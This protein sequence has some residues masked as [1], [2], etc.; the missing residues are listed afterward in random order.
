[1]NAALR[2]LLRHLAVEHGR[3]V[4]LYRRIVRP[5][6]DE[7]AAYL[8]RHGGLRAMGE[9]CSIQM[10]TTISD[11][12]YVRLGDNVRLSGCTLFGHDGSVNM[13]AAA[14]GVVL[15]RVGP[16]DIRDHV[17][18]G[19]GAVVLPG[20]TIGPYALVAAGAVVNRDVPP[21]S[22]VGGVPARP[23]G[24]LD[25]YVRRLAEQTAQLPWAHLLAQRTHDNYWQ[26]Q[27]EIER[28]RLATWFADEPPAA[29]AG[30][31]EA[32]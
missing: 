5:N 6:G 30:G 19:H 27:P 15:D 13:L 17:Y 14:Y 22:I 1:M 32:A 16:I 8:R 10:N 31:E 4:G 26:I 2:R 21:N 24:A 12:G 25:A 23:L 11:P 20:V 29:A 18:I 3:A 7:W 9:R 28:L